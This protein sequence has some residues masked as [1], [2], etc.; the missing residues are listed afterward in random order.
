MLP[1]FSFT[2]GPKAEWLG[3][4]EAAATVAAGSL[5]VL[6][7]IATVE[8]WIVTL[9]MTALQ[10]NSEINWGDT[11]RSHC[12]S[13]RER[14][15]WKWA[16]KRRERRCPAWQLHASAG[17]RMRGGPAHLGN[18]SGALEEMGD[19]GCR[20]GRDVWGSILNDL[21]HLL[22][23]WDE[24]LVGWYFTSLLK[25]TCYFAKWNNSSYSS[26]LLAFVRCYSAQSTSKYSI[27]FHLRVQNAVYFQPEVSF[28]GL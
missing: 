8:Q 20:G 18:T 12:S 16:A 5:T 4:G 2:P 3:L 23:L 26:L 25:T 27:L 19:P 11:E 10:I 15:A 22:Y 6:W 13:G 7:R 9:P 21:L 14:A 24:K 28:T 17:T 1:K